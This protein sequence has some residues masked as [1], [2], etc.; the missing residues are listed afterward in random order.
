MWERAIHM[1]AEVP[2]NKSRNMRIFLFLFLIACDV[3]RTFFFSISHRFWGHFQH[4][5]ES[6][7][8][9]YTFSKEIH[10]HFR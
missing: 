9:A 5:F 2:G 10:Q 6:P 3:L 7:D 1:H 8:P 4:M